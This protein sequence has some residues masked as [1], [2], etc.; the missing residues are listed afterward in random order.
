MS[1][2]KPLGRKLPKS[3]DFG[4]FLRSHDLLHEVAHGFSRFI[5]LLSGGVGVGAEGKSSVVVAQHT[6]HR[7]DVYTVLQCQGC[8]GMAEV[9]ESDVFQP[10]V[11]QDLLM[12]VD[13][14]IRVVPFASDRGGEHIGIARVRFMFLNQQVYRHLRDGDFSGRS[15]RLGTG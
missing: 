14:G 8:E 7:F 6:G 13:H 10:G 11:L 9:V 1:E 12:K 15:L 4:S 3:F 2:M 5:L